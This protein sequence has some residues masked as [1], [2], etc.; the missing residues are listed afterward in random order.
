MAM[1]RDNEVIII[2]GGI[3]GLCAAIALRQAGFEAR[4]Y[5]RT[6]EMGE[7]GAGISLWANAVKALNKIGLDEAV[8]AVSVP[9]KRGEIRTWNGKML[10]DIESARLV[11]QYGAAHIAVHRA[12]L[13]AV[14]LKA[15]G[16]G[17]LTLG[18]KCTGFEQSA[19][20][21]RAWF[22]GGREVQGRGLIGADG[23][24]SIVRAQLFGPEA[25]RYSGYTSWRGVTKFESELF[26]V[27]LGVEAWGRGQR[28]GITHI[29]EGRV[30]WFATKN[31]PAKGQDKPG[32]VK[33]KLLSMFKGW[34][35]PI[36]A[37]IEA[38]AE[39]AILRTDIQD[40]KPRLRWTEGRVTLLGDAAHPMTPN[41][42]QGACQAIEDAVVLAECLRQESDLEA[43]LQQYEKRRIPRTGKVVRQA[44]QLGQIGQLENPLLCW[45]RNKVMKF[46]PNS[47]AA[48]Q[49][50]WIVGYDV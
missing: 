16:E 30:Y 40:R 44:R 43:A 24:N 14:L 38:T 18:A 41:L 10:S 1:S 25:P 28:F 22:E 13:Q 19:S 5:E 2:G 7:I 27:G 15:L 6:Q 34:Q 32:T 42:G 3:G 48:K 45:G 29:S 20:G 4:V 12:D 9:G 47:L 49:L 26:P 50:G 37:I 36:E 11:K 46:T 35:A 39:E 33:Q 21:V 31:A 8:L 17:A 23:L